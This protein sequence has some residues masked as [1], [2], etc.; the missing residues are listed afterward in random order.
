MKFVALNLFVFCLGSLPAFAQDPFCLLVTGTHVIAADGTFLGIVSKNA[1]DA[2]SIGN[3]YGQ[4]GPY[5]AASILNAYGVY[6]S[7]YSA[8]SPWNAY[9]P[10]AQVPVLE[11]PD[12]RGNKL[13]RLTINPSAP[14]P[15]CDPARVLACI[16][17]KP[18]VRRR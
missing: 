10:V 17:V 8:K 2:K 5:A 11:R 4:H 18:P 13:C 9:A 16:G 3:P 12:F 14:Q 15:V 1:Y 7:K 6:G